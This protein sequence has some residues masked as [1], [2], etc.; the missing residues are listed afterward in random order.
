M[1]M[2]A[3]GVVYGDIGTSPLYT[4]KVSLSEFPV[5]DNE[6]ILGVL[7]ILFWMLM[8]VVSLKYVMLVLRADNHGEGGT[9]AL[10]EL[11]V[12]GL[13]GRKKGVLTVLGLIGAA[14]FYGDSMI[15][16]AISVLSAIE[17][18][19][20][21]SHRL[22]HW[23]VPLSV[24]VLA[25][26]FFIQSRGTGTVGKLFGPIM[27]LWFVT[28][29]VLGAWRIAQTPQI[30]Q[31]LNPMWALTFIGDAPWGTFLLLGAIVL[32]LT[33]AE[34]LYADMGHY[35]RPAIQRAWFGLVLPALVLCYF[36]QGALLMAD[37]SAI[38]N[39]FFLMAPSWG[40]VPLVV[41]ATVATVIASQS[42]ISGAFSVTRQAVQLGFWPRMV[43]LHTSAREEGQVY[44]PRVNMLLFV[45][46]LVLV[47]AF[48]SSDRLAQAY[49]FAVTG[50]M[51]MTSMLAFS[52]LPRKSV[53][54]KRVLWMSV[55]SVFLILDI[56]LFSSNA[57]KIVEGG[58]LPLVVGLTILAMMLTWKQGREKMHE[59]LAGDQQ[60]LKRFM[61]A[62]EEYP[63]TRVEGT[64]V[65]MSMIV[66]TV[67]PAL[68]HNLK[69]NKILHEQ[70]VFLNVQSADKPYVPFNER[71]VLERLSR[72]SWQ[73]VA[74]WGFK[75]EPNVPQL[76]EQIAQ[77]HPELN[78]EPM[79]T[80][81]FLSRQTVIVVRRLSWRLSWR[82]SLFAFMARNATRSTRFYKIPPNRVVEMGMQFEL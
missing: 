58:W 12:R 64:A 59:S 35:G 1:L 82:R 15:T 13:S 52:V 57:L 75:Q 17:G 47:L 53:G 16:P 62:L 8:V 80:S 78:L 41:L 67:P 32:A 4:I 6:H 54:A 74:T 65:F 77:E 40:L 38:K 73:V 45:A 5:L 36:G 71:F 51:L 50:T 20:I 9:L 81:Y 76:L 11:A 56:L 37:P 68:L 72:S 43:I 25:G 61:E 26:L 66:D 70:A 79:R 63:P 42:V 34:A 22:D 49:G 23:V 39:P 18:V 14:L 48:E 3:L 69:H 55:L 44:L 21:V 33:G 24:L 29:G 10:M 60:P 7:S 31:A 28:L 30:L 2:G 19:S 46:V 27:L